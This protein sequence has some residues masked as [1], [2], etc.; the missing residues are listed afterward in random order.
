[1]DS[2]KIMIETW[3]RPNLFDPIA[4]SDLYHKHNNFWSIIGQIIGGYKSN[5]NILNGSPINVQFPGIFMYQEISYDVLTAIGKNREN[6]MF[7]WNTIQNFTNEISFSNDMC[8]LKKD[9]KICG[10]FV[11]QKSWNTNLSIDEKAT[12]QKTP[13]K[14][15]RLCDFN[16]SD[17][18][19]LNSYNGI[20]W[21]VNKFEFINMYQPDYFKNQNDVQFG[22]RSS[23]LIILKY[24]D[25]L[26]NVMSVHGSGVNRRGD[27]KN[28][29]FINMIESYL[30]K[31]DNETKPHLTC[32][33]GDFNMT[34]N[35]RLDNNLMSKF[36][37]SDLQSNTH[38][39]LKSNAIQQFADK[40]DWI[41]YKINKPI[42]DIPITAYSGDINNLK[43]PNNPSDH[44]KIGIILPIIVQRKVTGS[45]LAPSSSSFLPQNQAVRQSRPILHQPINEKMSS[46]N[47]PTLDELHSM[48]SNGYK[49]GYNRGY[50]DKLKD[51]PNLYQQHQQGGY[52]DKFIKYKVSNN[53]LQKILNRN[54]NI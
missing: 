23:Y 17:G 29:A 4:N 19:P 18:K 13:Q 47:P 37:T 46:S 43:T 15:F 39:D 7:E 14:S 20:V 54:N 45:A 35:R 52:Y 1:M 42:I 40:L 21:N 8:V 6:V 2:E 51:L 25:Y 49:A 32:I 3:N 5:V 30:L 24:K 16:D 50:N 34:I 48:Y 53:K 38:I 22:Y 33:A 11:K 27:A 41:F 12:V 28:I 9:N 10:M 44:I 26:F 36:I 31:I